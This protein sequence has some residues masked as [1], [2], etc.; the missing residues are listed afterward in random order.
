MD[1]LNLEI[2]PD[3][4]ITVKTS[5]ISDSNHMSADALMVELDRMM[6]GAV[7]I[8]SNPDFDAKAHIHHNKKL[9]SHAGGAAH[10]H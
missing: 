10:Q 9:H 5:E 2:L 7:K 3:G 8:E 1:T 6:G 4:T